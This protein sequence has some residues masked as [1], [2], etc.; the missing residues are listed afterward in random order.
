MEKFFLSLPF[1][2]KKISDRPML[3]KVM[4][5]VCWLSIDKII[6]MGVSFFVGVWVARYL[7][8]EGYGLLNYA[9]AFTTLFGSFASLGLQEIV[10]RE[11]VKFPEKAFDI[12]GTAFFLRLISG[13]ITVILTI[14]VGFI[15]HKGNFQTL[16][17]L[18]LIS[19]GYVFQSFFVIDYYFQSKILS[20]YTVIAQNIAFFITTAL[21]IFLLL[22]QAQVI[23]FAFAYTF[24]I[25]LGGVF[26]AFIYQ[27]QG[28]HVKK[29]RF[30]SVL[31]R[32]LLSYSWP[33][34]LSN[35]AIMIY[36]RTDQVMLKAMIGE[37][38]VGLYSAAVSLSEVWYMI[39]MVVS[40]SVFPATIEAKKV[41]EELYYRRLGQFFALMGW[42]AI[43]IAL[44]VSLLSGFIVNLLF[45]QAYIES[46]K[47]LTIHIW[48]GVFVFLGVARGQWIMAENL[49]KYAFYFTF[50]ATLLNICLNGILIPFLGI[51]G[52]AWATLIS[53][54]FSVIVF[55]AF[56]SLTRRSSFLLIKSLIMKDEISL[57]FKG[58]HK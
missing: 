47:V 3:L 46:A 54:F 10:V 18:G 52:A 32:E 37:K 33:L 14:G 6:R 13:L 8:P 11:I 24:E 27:R 1:M 34:M 50:M 42:A 35:V 53:Q 17:M 58:E 44:P 5:N 23:W 31:A 51:V 7:T 26:L 55:P 29:W 9:I 20:K 38:A 28:L 4:S 57:L 30:D 21:K 22:I 43:A 25:F 45:G 16:L 15:F 19:L 2:G 48:A 56:F 12:V 49:Q 39:P 36:M 41:S 40:T